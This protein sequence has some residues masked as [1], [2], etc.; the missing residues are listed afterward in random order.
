[1][2]NCRTKDVLS[3]LMVVMPKKSSSGSSS[4]AI[5]SKLL[6]R[7]IMQRLS[8][9]G[10]AYLALTHII[11]GRPRPSE[12]PVD[13]AIPDSSWKTSSLTDN[14][15][16]KVSRALSKGNARPMSVLRRLHN[17]VENLSDVGIY[18]YQSSSS[19]PHSSI[20]GGYDILSISPRNEAVF[21]AACKSANLAEII[22][23]DYSAGRGGLKLPYKIRSSDV[24]AVVE[25]NAVFEIPFAPALLHEKQRKGLVQ[26]C[27]ELQMASLGLRP[28]VL[29]SSGDR[30]IDDSDAGAMALRLPEDLINLFQTVL[31]FDASTARTSIGATAEH[32]IRKARERRLGQSQV[33][34]A[35]F[36]SRN[37]PS[38][39]LKLNTP[40]KKKARDDSP[41]P[42]SEEDNGFEDGF[43]AMD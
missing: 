1:M 36:E 38:V 17:V 5:E 43:I 9:T 31:R 10:F 14:R 11:F 12:D 26:T 27:R 40:A 34:D 4:D 42:S 37:N 39:K 24:K 13:V 16:E 6:I 21:Q 8:H 15:G 25:R 41:Q 35:Y 30:I 28:K 3:D 23:L 20:L 22:T 19:Q 29:F 7:E 2:L 18:A 33:A 32:V